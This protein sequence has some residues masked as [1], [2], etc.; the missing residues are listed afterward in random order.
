MAKKK[1]SSKINVTSTRIAEMGN[2]LLNIDGY[3]DWEIKELHLNRASDEGDSVV[4]K[5][6]KLSNGS[7]KLICKRA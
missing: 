3:S 5:W 2:T 1:F 6:V 4:C 7:W